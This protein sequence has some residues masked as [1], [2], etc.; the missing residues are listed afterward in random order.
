MIKYLLK[1]K[2]EN[3][4]IITQNIEFIKK[5]KLRKNA[6]INA[7]EKIKNGNKSKDVYLCDLCD[8]FPSHPMSKIRQY[9]LNLHDIRISGNDCVYV[10]NKY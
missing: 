2:N 3:V 1:L 7:I 6:I 5:E 4:I 10:I 8:Y 9:I